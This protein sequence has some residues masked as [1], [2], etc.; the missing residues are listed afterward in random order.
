MKVNLVPG[1]MVC[2][3]GLTEMDTS[4]AFVTSSVAVA[5][6]EPSAAAMVVVPGARALARPV[7]AIPATAVL[8][9]V[10]ETF[11]VTP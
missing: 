3:D 10:Q 11:P 9:E 6:T 7:R 8:E 4:V 5:L 1:G 2:P